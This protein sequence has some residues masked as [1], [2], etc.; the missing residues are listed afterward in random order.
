MPFQCDGN[1]PECKCWRCDDETYARY[2][3]SANRAEETARKIIEEHTGKPYALWC[4]GGPEY[5][6]NSWNALC[7]AI[8]AALS[9]M[10]SK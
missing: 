5:K 9:V 3:E 1:R 4:S 8:A 6:H 7:D 2:I 10:E